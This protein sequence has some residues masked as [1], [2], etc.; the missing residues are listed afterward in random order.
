MIVRALD[1]VQNLALIEVLPILLVLALSPHGLCL[2]VQR[3]VAKTGCIWLALGGSDHAPHLNELEAPRP[4]IDILIP[5]YNDPALLSIIKEEERK[6]SRS[7]SDPQVSM[8]KTVAPLVPSEFPRTST[9][10]VDAKPVR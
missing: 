6:I 8:A 5:K 7:I 10:K 3:Q 4:D 2:A 9:E 1:D